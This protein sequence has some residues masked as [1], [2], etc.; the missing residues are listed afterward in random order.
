MKEDEGV[1]VIGHFE[2]HVPFGSFCQLLTFLTFLTFSLSLLFHNSDLSNCFP[3]KEVGWLQ[4]KNVWHHFKSTAKS[5]K[6]HFLN[7]NK[8]NSWNASTMTNFLFVKYIEY[9]IFVFLFITL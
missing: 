8:E 1:S 7:F 2:K 5:Q 6:F 4:A 9:N 3:L